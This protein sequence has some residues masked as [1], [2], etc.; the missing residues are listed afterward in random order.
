M[1]KNNLKVKKQLVETYINIDCDSWLKVL[2][3]EKWREKISRAVQKTCEHVKVHHGELTIAFM[4]DES[5]QKL[6]LRF[7]E[8][9]KPTNVLSFPCD[10]DNY[11]GDVALAYQTIQNEAA[12]QGK[13]FLNHVM[14]LVVHGVLHLLGYDHKDEADAIDMEQAEK[15]I[16]QHFHIKDPYL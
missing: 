9:D 2:P 8:K 5:V 11:L 4:D 16:L 12:N 3:E 7:R 1:L 14:H 10:E 15:Q 13:P 6:N